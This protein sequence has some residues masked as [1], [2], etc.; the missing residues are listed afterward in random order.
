M[1]RVVVASIADLPEQRGVALALG[2]LRVALF[3]LG[4]RVFAV[5]DRCPHRGFPLHDGAVDGSTVRCRTHGSCFDLATG[6]LTRGPAR[7]GVRVYPAY[8]VDGQVELDVPE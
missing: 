8:V 6:D 3:R 4:A 1:A 2:G 5:E 7:R